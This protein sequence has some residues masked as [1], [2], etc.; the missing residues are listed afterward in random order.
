LLIFFFFLGVG[1]VGL[2]LSKV[3]RTPIITVG[4]Q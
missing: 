1:G 2:A 3:N 4:S